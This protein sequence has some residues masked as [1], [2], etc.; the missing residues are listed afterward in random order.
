MRTR[1]SII[2]AA[3]TVCL[4]GCSNQEV[5]FVTDTTV[6]VDADMKLGHVTIAYDRTHG[7]FGPKA[8]SGTAPMVVGS[9]KTDADVL[10]PHLSQLYATGSAATLVTRLTPTTE[11]P[12]LD[13]D[14]LNFMPG[15]SDSPMFFGTTSTV[16]FKLAFSESQLASMTLGIKRRELSVIPLQP[17]EVDHVKGYAY[18]PVIASVEIAG[19]DKALQDAGLAVREFFATG[20]PA[21]N[22]ARHGSIRRVFQDEAAQSLNATFDAEDAAAKSVMTCYDKTPTTNY[23]SVWQNAAD[24]DILTPEQLASYQKR[25]TDAGIVASDDEAARKAKLEGTVDGAAGPSAA[26][27]GQLSLHMEDFGASD[28]RSSALVKHA[29]FVCSKVT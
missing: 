3:A 1:Y 25:Y 18:A 28:T 21:E 10:N 17:V 14:N 15:S 5:M 23:L 9:I 8:D 6:G 27:R 19:N 2:F 11:P 4:A 16:G 7:M 26:Y 22:L 24:N 13:S 29:Q 20:A 12:I